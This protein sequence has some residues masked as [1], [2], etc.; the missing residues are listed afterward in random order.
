MKN[1]LK[2]IGWIFMFIFVFYMAIANVVFSIRH[3]WATDTERFI[4]IFDMMS[5]N[6]IEYNE[7]RER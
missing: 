6:K 1:N 7:M 3:P 2:A 5:F 4:H